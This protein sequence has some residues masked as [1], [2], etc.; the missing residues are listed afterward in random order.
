MLKHPA[1]KICT[2]LQKERE[3]AKGQRKREELWQLPTSLEF[4]LW[5]DQGM[6]IKHHSHATNVLW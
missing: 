1:N 4:C 2:D 5:P 3:I 6:V